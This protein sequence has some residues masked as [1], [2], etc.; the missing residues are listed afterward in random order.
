MNRIQ[1][2][3]IGMWLGM[4]FL[5]VTVWSALPV[6]DAQ[7]AKTTTVKVK[8]I[9]QIMARQLIP[10]SDGRGHFIGFLRRQGKAIFAD[11][12]TAKYDNTHFMDAW[13]GRGATFKGYTTFTFQDG[14]KIFL[15]W[16]SKVTLVPGKRPIS[17]GRGVITGG[18]GKYQGIKGKAVFSV[19][20][21][22]KPA[23]GGRP[24]SV[25]HAVLKY[26]LP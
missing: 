12:R 2:T 8:T 22:K 15:T 1:P 4:T 11:G 26:T 7:A 17:H 9:H 23:A 14:S 18:T 3:L 16:T 25:A 24:V 21:E 10:A 19:G 6:A 13:R 5:A 20:R